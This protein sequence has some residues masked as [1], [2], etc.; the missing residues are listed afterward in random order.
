MHNVTDEVV[1]VQPMHDDDDAAVLTAQARKNFIVESFVDELYLLDVV[2]VFDRKWIVDDDNVGAITG[3]RAGNGGGVD[4]SALG[5]SE[6]TCTFPT[7]VDSRA[8]ITTEWSGR[9]DLARG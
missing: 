6:I 2:G 7:L 4:A 5:S 1:F 9:K 3:D 8:E